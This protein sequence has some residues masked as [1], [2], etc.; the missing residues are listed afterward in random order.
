[1]IRAFNHATRRFPL[2]LC[3]LWDGLGAFGGGFGGPLGITGHHWAQRGNTGAVEIAAS[4]GRVAVIG[5]TGDGDQNSVKRWSIMVNLFA[6]GVSAGALVIGSD[7]HGPPE[8]PGTRHTEQPPP[9]PT[10][11]QRP[12]S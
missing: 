6:A 4:R 2:R 11:T 1:M 8:N 10:S 9:S 12:G 7:R 5:C 3:S